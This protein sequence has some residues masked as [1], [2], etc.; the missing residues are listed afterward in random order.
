MIFKGFLHYQ[1]GATAYD[2]RVARLSAGTVVE[3]AGAY[4]MTADPV[5]LWISEQ[6]ASLAR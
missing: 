1:I 5:T 4:A 6:F 3:Q 2:E